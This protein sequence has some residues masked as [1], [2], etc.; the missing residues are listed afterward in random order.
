MTLGTPNYHALPPRRVLLT[1]ADLEPVQAPPRM[2]E[3]ANAM[4]KDAAARGCLQLQ[5]RR[6][7]LTRG[8]T[9]FSSVP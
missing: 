6:C 4:C 2:I 1:T 7:A 9:K 8:R 5:Q 3:G